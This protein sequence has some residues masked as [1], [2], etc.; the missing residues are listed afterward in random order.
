MK[1]WGWLAAV[2]G[3]IA[4][5]LGLAYLNRA[6]ILAMVAHARLPHI[7]PNHPVTWAMGPAEPPKGDRPPNVVFILADD[8]GF[9]DIT[10]NGG[11]VANGAV[12]TPNID[13]IGHQG[14]SFANGY[15]GNATCAP[16]R[17]AIMTGRY[18]TRFGFEF[19]PA[20]V[21]FERLV[22]TEAEPG[23]IVKPK[24]FKDRLK[25]MPAGSTAPTPEAVN[26]LAVPASEITIAEVLKAK[27]YH[28][29]Q[30]GKWHLGGTKGSRPEDQGFDE[31]L[32]FI[33]GASM[34]LPEKDPDSVNS[35]QPW[36]AIDK[37]LWPNLPY[38]VQFNGSPM[39]APRGYM[40]DY[41]GEEAVKAIH[42]NRNR[43]FFIYF[44]PNAI[45]TPLQAK[46]EDYDALPQIKDHRLRVY[47]A[48]AR[49]LDRNVGRIL[50]ALKDEGLDD[51]TLVIFT[52]DNGGANYIGLPDI[53][54]P[55]RG[56]KATFFE[57]GIHT[58]FF[59]RWP[60]VLPAGTTYPYPVGHVDIFATAA[61]AAGAA[62]PTDRKIDG[63]NLLPFAEGKDAARPHKAL[64][65]RS[66]SYKTLLDGDWKL[67]VS[68][69]QNKVWLYDL[70][71]D[72]TEKNDLSKAQPAKVAELKAKLAAEDAQMAK[73]LWPSLLQGP[74]FVDHPSG[75]PQKK[76]EEYILWD[77]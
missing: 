46:K 21:G 28:T 62:V 42:A 71:A 68:E 18:A 2:A 11:G 41:L 33:S 69:A 53:N 14:V 19:T 1:L 30:F 34:Y 75:Q 37:F 55:Y 57:G 70:A 65:W 56:W 59:M 13:S 6:S 61:G 40:T 66:G 27:G 20:P 24:F 50:Q 22:G 48:M 38:Q 3:V 60:G 64:Y 5:G 36:D 29:I 32:G 39:F 8:L 77:N 10:F 4:M 26:S 35:K 76:G 49:A 72:P 74:I 7:E 15:A 44:A 23:A 9:N 43:P 52:S 16:S 67:Q 58:P 51:N 12:P 45:H 47:G 25:D 73:P 17:A 63:V 54:R 31:A